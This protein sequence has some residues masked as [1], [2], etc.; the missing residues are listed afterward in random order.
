MRRAKIVLVAILT[1]ALAGCVLSGKPKTVSAPAVVP[2]PA[3]P[4]PSPEKLSIPQTDVQLP[5]PQA[6]PPG[7]LATALP[8]QPAAPAPAKP[9]PPPPPQRTPSRGA[10]A[11]APDPPPAA[12]PEQPQRAPIQEILSA[13]E[14]K[15]YREKAHK[16]REDTHAVLLA[17]KPHTANQRRQEQEINNFLKQSEQ[18]E[19]S[20]DLRLASQL[21]ERAF[22]LAKE[23]QSGK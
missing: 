18:A 1:I 21:A 11:R 3:L 10:P 17:A 12:E 4:S 7:A 6:V 19:N 13:D 22:T 20:G 8:E 5:A 14:Q 2:Q 9:T 15:S 16:N 23:L